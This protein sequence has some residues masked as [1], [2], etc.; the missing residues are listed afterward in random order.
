MPIQPEQHEK[1]KFPRL[2]ITDGSYGI[3]FQGGG[4]DILNTRLVNLS[5][6][7]CGLEVQMVDAQS[8]EMGDIMESLYL[9]H[10]DL[11]LVPL[12]GVIVRLLGKVPGKTSGYIL[13][14]IEFLGIT[15][16]VQGLIADHVAVQ[17]RQ[18]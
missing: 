3:R 2:S 13:M 7:G 11:P 5:A 16:F 18:E 10:P 17:L 14:G 12:S 9:D 8:L 15:P 6:G 1:R 4:V